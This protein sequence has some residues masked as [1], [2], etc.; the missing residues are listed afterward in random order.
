MM[1]LHIDIAKKVFTTLAETK[2]VE[3]VA[4][5]KAANGD[6]DALEKIV[7][8]FGPEAT[9]ASAAADQFIQRLL[10]Q[11]AEQPSPIAQAG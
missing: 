7:L 11:K 2:A 6:K 8:D 10:P 3:I 5:V 4:A 1:M 9:V